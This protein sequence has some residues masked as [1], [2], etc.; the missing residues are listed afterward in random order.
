MNETVNFE[1]QY[2]DAVKIEA[3]DLVVVKST[4]GIAS[5][6]LGTSR[7]LGAIFQVG[8]VFNSGKLALCFQHP[9]GGVWY[10]TFE[11]DEVE[12]AAIDELTLLEQFNQ[13]AV[14]GILPEPPNEQTRLA[15]V[16]LNIFEAQRQ[17]LEAERDGYLDTVKSCQPVFEAYGA[18]CR[19]AVNLFGHMPIDFTDWLNDYVR[20]HEAM[21]EEL[22]RRENDKRKIETLRRHLHDL[23]MLEGT[24]DAGE[25]AKRL[26][27]LREYE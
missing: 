1:K 23:A 5:E 16:G 3:G 27:I 20:Q 25:Q 18:A 15:F 14:I 10:E 13:R 6:Y 26:A 11:R 24:S 7:D 22:K 9:E 19:E 8:R 2:E 12:L 21:K 4:A 17:A